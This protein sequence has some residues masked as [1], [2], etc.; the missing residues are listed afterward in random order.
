MKH[1]FNEDHIDVD[2]ERHMA[3]V[4]MLLKCCFA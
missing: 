1:N 2:G 3:M 4:K